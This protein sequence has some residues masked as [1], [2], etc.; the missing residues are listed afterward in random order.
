[1][2]VAPEVGPALLE[3]AANEDVRMVF[4]LFVADVVNSRSVAGEFAGLEPPLKAFDTTEV[5]ERL[6]RLEAD[7]QNKA[8]KQ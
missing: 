3:A 5:H 8:D 4:G 7:M 2:E 6:A 1:M